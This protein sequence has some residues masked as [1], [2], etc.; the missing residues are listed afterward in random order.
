M[1]FV[2]RFLP[3]AV[4]ALVLIAFWLSGLGSQLSWAALARNQAWLGAWISLHPVAAPALYVAI[5]AVATALSLPEAA[6]LTVAGGLLFGT[7]L[8]GGLAVIGSAIGAVILFAAARSAF[9]SWMEKRAGPR[10]LR[11]RTELHRN[12][13][14]YL[15]AI[16]LVPLFPFWLVNLAAALAGMRVLPYVGAT[17]LGIIPATVVYAAIGSGIGNVLASGQRPDLAVVFSPEILGPL[18]GLA[19][20]ALLPIVW[21]HWKR[22]NA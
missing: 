22:A 4:L 10:L 3:L 14:L 21:R 15:L 2:H 6:V 9:A 16:R 7:W 1:R 17:F 20:L 8:G 13:F 11:L 5:Y 18:L 12:G 19:A